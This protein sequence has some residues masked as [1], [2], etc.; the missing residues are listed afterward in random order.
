[1][2]VYGKYFQFGNRGAP[3][4]LIAVRERLERALPDAELVLLPGPHSPYRE[5]ARCGAWQ[6]LPL[7]RAGIDL[8]RLAGRGPATLRRRARAYGIVGEAD[9][10]AI[11][12]ASGYA[13]G[14]CWPQRA[15]RYAAGELER[16]ARR[17]R[18]YLFLPQAFGPFVRNTRATRRFA[19]ALPF[20]ARIYA[21]DAR[22]REQL[23]VLGPNVAAQAAECP[24][25]T[26][27]LPG[28]AAAADRWGVTRSTV[29]IVPNGELT[30]ARNPDAAARAAY[31][32]LLTGLARY[33]RG[34]GYAV[35]VLNHEGSRDAEL[36]ALIAREAGAPDIIADADPR[37]A[38]GVL[39]AAAAVV[40]SRF[41]ACA[42]ALAHG[43]PCL[44]TGGNDDFAALYED[45]GV[46]D[47]LLGPGDAGHAAAMLARLL[48][49]RQARAPALAARRAELAARVETMWADVLAVLSATGAAGPVAP[50]R[51]AARARRG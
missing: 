47:W 20:A 28:D 2:L 51:E 9:L 16:L 27:T 40:A 49:E 30:T 34:Q 31:V 29:L 25:F 32:A 5:R 10:D 3:R 45:F 13:Y 12:D 17:Q 21:R 43:V 36:C 39:G 41:Q 24:D 50:V 1:M 4:A 14:D 8:G 18:P 26:L 19:A 33:A 6:L 7:R 37:A 38:R 22:S 46:R 35:R 42:G 44:G 11:L 48:G 23:A 15:L